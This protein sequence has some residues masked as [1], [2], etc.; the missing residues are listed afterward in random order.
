M[1]DVD[2]DVV[3]QQ[4]QSGHTAPDSV[5]EGRVLESVKSENGATALMLLS[6]TGS[7]TS[8]AL[9]LV[10]LAG[11]FVH[12]VNQVD[13]IGS[14]QRNPRV[15]RDWHGNDVINKKDRIGDAFFLFFQTAAYMDTKPAD[16]TL[17]TTAVERW[18]GASVSD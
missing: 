13:V 16:L 6:S 12:K 11:S 2:L 4:Y 15:E 3:E 8:Q 10:D 7:R 1:S 17:L 9:G 14:F 5:G 18:I